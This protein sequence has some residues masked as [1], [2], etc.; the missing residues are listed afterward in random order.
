[1]EL[2]CQDP[3]IEDEIHILGICP[4]YEDLRQKLLPQTSSLLYSDIGQ[5]FRH[6]WTIRDIGGL[7]TKVN[8]RRFPKILPSNNK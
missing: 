3:I 5:I 8:E 4:F 2:P 6:A 1:M 7:L